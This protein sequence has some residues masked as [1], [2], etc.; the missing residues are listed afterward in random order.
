LQAAP[1]PSDDWLQPAVDQSGLKRFIETVRAKLGLVLA[2]VAM[3]MLVAVIYLLLANKVYEAEAKLL[4]Q[5]VPATDTSLSGLG[6]IRESADP[7]LDV[8][9][10]AQLVTTPQVAEAAA[11]ELDDGRSA[12]TLLSKVRAD[13]VGQSNIVAVLAEGST[14]ESASNSA[15]AFAK[16][17]V[18][19]RTDDLHDRIDAILPGLKKQ[20]ESMTAGSPAADSLAQQVIQ[21]ESLRAGDDPT[22]RFET[23]AT[24]PDGPHWP[25]PLLTLIAALV[26]GLALGAAAAFI[27][28]VL[29]PRLKRELQLRENFRLPILARIP[30]EGG[31]SGDLPLRPLAISAPT[32]EAYRTLRATL[33]AP[34]PGGKRPRS[35]MVTSPSPSDGK[36]STALNLASALAAAGARTILIEADLRRPMMAKTMGFTP[37]HSITSV[38]R[39]EVSLT[40]ALTRAPGLSENLALLIADRPGGET[41]TAELFGLPSGERLVEEA[42]SIADCVVVDSPPLTAVIDALPLARNVDS[43]LIVVRLG[44]THLR[45]IRDLGELLAGNGIS[46]AGFAVVGAA[47][48][49]GIDYYYHQVVPEDGKKAETGSTKPK[50]PDRERGATAK[51]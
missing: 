1:K 41:A 38:L 45:R 22:F 18:D 31:V 27:A 13:P 9:T 12:E 28:R 36:T 42:Q 43:L 3:T 48:P 34:G 20:L 40:D 11:A 5:P 23:P 30:H 24:P 33:T 44:K 37:P 19:V 39:G 7:T 50:R 46:P 10:A 8:E 26:L 35:F 49:R 21:L 6:L 47:R 16:G 51:L 14:P 2:I 32:L 29:D 25:R 4:I 15:N 17:V